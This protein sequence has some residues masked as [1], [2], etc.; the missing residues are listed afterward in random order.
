[1]DEQRK[2]SDDT[3]P[4]KAGVGREMGVLLSI[5]TDPAAISVI[6]KRVRR[7]DR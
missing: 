4:R 1:M 3:I 2:F 5:K 7:A 6:E